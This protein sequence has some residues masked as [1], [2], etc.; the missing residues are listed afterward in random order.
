MTIPRMLRASAVFSLLVIAGACGS[1]PRRQEFRNAS[2]SPQQSTN[3]VPAATIVPVIAP[4]PM[5]TVAPENPSD[6]T[7]PPRDA[8]PETPPA[9]AAPRVH[10]VKGTNAILSAPNKQLGKYL[11][12][13]RVGESVALRQTE[14]VPSADCAK[15][16][17]AL[18]P[19]GYICNDSFVSL[20]PSSEHI[21]S[22][23]ATAPREGPY[24][25]R[26]AI[27]NGAPMYNRIPTKREQQRFEG[28]FGPVG[29]YEKLPF[30]QAAHEDL[31]VDENIAPTDPI[32]PF[33]EGGQMIRPGRQGLIR[34][35]IP[36]GSM[37][38]Y[39]KAFAV[40]GRTYLLSV[41]LTAVP[42]DRVRPF[43][44]SAFHGFW[45]EG[46]QTLP[47]AWF[48]Q[49]PRM[50]WRKVPNGTVESL[51]VTFP[52]RTYARLTGQSIDVAGVKYLETKEREGSDVVWVAEEDA[53]VVEARTNLPFAVR[54]GQK[55]IIVRISQGTL[56]AY[57]GMRPVYATLISPGAGGIPVAGIDP[58]K[59]STTP[60]GTYNITFKDRAATMSPEFGDNRSFWIADVPH[61]Q[62]FKAP[63]AL[64]A[65][66]WHERFGEPT[67]AGCVNL[68]PLDAEAMFHWTD[69]PVPPGWQGAV[70]A[71]ASE[72]GPMTAVVIAR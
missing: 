15:G 5:A 67:S 48:R 60:L 18:E 25:Y 43:R 36:R 20:N 8:A 33:L 34:Q 31:A 37:L 29:K 1:G 2:N 52:A 64:H 3:I 35:K 40:E 9:K 10:A 19:R 32:P 13:I 65:A 71:G 28:A 45:L 51:S 66:Y 57:D 38:S 14:T 6:T 70:G 22:M 21:V 53:T 12:Y 62:Y 23:G 54:E 39:T 49:K 4:V 30:F 72:N 69:P 42:A 63:F 41:D 61:T 50:K 24:P 26:Y 44:P 46:D 16:Y 7:D 11:G 56:V 59:A 47:I 58:V 17:F 27:S 55:W 68:S